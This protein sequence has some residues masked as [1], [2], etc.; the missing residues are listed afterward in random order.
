[1]SYTLGVSIA[2]DRLLR[3]TA[4]LSNDAVNLFNKFKVVFPLKLKKE[5]FT[6]WTPDNID[7]VPSNT[8]A[9]ESF[10]GT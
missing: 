1:M 5:I 9:K 4:A 10:H 6:T 7:H 3:L 2:Y 8:T